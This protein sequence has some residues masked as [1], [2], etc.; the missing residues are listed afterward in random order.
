ML[1]H[2]FDYELRDLIDMPE[3]FLARVSPGGSPLVFQRRT[4]GMPAAVVW[5]D[6][7]FERVGLHTTLN[8]VYAFNVNKK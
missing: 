4:V 8:P 5:F 3:R 1:D 6:N 2:A 7:D